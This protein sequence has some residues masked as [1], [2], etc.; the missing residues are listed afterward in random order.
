VVT[1]PGIAAVFGSGVFDLGTALFFTGAAL[2]VKLGTAVFGSGAA[3]L[4]AERRRF[5]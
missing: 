2:L 5:A 1:L 4:R 3:L